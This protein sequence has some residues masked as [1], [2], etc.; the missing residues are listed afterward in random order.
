MD[1]NVIID[2]CGER[3][4]SQMINEKLVRCKEL[5]FETIAISVIVDASKE[6][7]SI[8]PPPIIDNLIIPKKL[9]VLTRLTVK[10]S[11]NI[12]IYKVNKSKERSK[13]DLLAY[14]PQNPKILQYL[15]MGNTT[16]EIMTFELASRLDYNLFKFS[17]KSIEAQGICVELN[18]GPAQLG[19]TM[20]RNTISNGQSLTEKSTKNII[21]SSGVD[22]IFR[23]RSPK[24]AKYLGVLFL[25]SINKCHE[26]VFNN[27]HKAIN[28]GKNNS[29]PAS[30]A[31]EMVS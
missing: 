17:M 30:S 18:Y 21:L 5:G 11:E 1:L 27:G 14:E 31:I 4:S 26:A 7:F 28:L 2:N 20:R 19:S 22:D 8:P 25:M 13:Y 16:F 10:V 29:N 12:Q 15:A 6:P 24:D 23:L 3:N 9:T